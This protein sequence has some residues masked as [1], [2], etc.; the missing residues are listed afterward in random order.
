[1]CTKQNHYGKMFLKK[2]CICMHVIYA[3]V[4]KNKNHDGKMVFL[5]ID[6][7]FGCE[8]LHM[9]VC[10]ICVVYM[11]VHKKFVIY[12]AGGKMIF[13]K[14]DSAFGCEEL[15]MHVCYVC[16]MYMYVHRTNT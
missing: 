3:Y 13:L 8:D 14:I 15:R 12:E 5:E 11:Y 2:T 4:H 10:C 9:H 16:V 6:S 1:M 7:A